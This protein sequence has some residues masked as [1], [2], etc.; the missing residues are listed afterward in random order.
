[1]KSSYSFYF[2]DPF[3]GREGKCRI[4]SRFSNRKFEPHE[5]TDL[6]TGLDYN[7]HL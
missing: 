6:R 5:I 3:T 7:E 4:K 2:T 1:M